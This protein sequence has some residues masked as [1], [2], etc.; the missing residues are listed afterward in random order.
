VLGQEAATE[1]RAM[2]QVLDR[3]HEPCGARSNCEVP[4]GDQ[5]A[6]GG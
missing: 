5:R 1:R 2:A 4:K 3:E 6:F